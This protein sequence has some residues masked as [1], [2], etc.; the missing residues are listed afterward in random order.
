MLI[1]FLCHGLQFVESIGQTIS[2]N[3]QGRSRPPELF[4]LSVLILHLRIVIALG[5]HVK[6][7]SL[8]PMTK[9][10]IDTQRP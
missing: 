4:T 3:K 8:Q 5:E 6:A 2:R 7:V 9:T 10:S 1:D